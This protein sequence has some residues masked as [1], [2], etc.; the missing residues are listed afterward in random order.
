MNLEFLVPTYFYLPTPALLF[1]KQVST[2][3]KITFS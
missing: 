3:V 2:Y 1:L